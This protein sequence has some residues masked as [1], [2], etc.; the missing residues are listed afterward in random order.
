MRD[1]YVWVWSNM[2]AV[3]CATSSD[4]DL[5]S[6]SALYIAAARSRESELFEDPYAI[7]FSQGK[8]ESLL[9]NLALENGVNESTLCDIVAI[10]TKWID[11]FVTMEVKAG[12]PQLIILGAGFDMRVQR[13]GLHQKN[14]LSIFLLETQTVLNYRHETLKQ[15]FPGLDL[16]TNQHHVPCNITRKGWYSALISHGFNP[17]RRSLWILEGL[18]MWFP[19]PVASKLLIK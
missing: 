9:K 19:A 7:A 1:S 14:Y 16:G 5:M 18:L 12:L 17:R 6:S 15:N 10:R 2:I 4:V 11:D 13:L 3:L 8:G